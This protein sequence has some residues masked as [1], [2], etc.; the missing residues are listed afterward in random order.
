MPDTA[1]AKRAA[2][3]MTVSCNEITGLNCQY[4][5]GADGN[6]NSTVGHHVDQVMALLS[7]HM[8]H[9]HQIG[10]GLE[11]RNRIR[12]TFTRAIR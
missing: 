5:A 7:I 9:A 8:G 2:A 12:D 1:A 11:E 10:L 3:H 4:V 6:T